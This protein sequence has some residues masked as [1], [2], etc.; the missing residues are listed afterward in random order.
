MR[1]EG[2]EGPGCFH[3]IVRRAAAAKRELTEDEWDIEVVMEILQ[4]EIEH[5][6]RAW[7]RSGR[8]KLPHCH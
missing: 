4:R 1:C 7:Q 5:S 2:P 8:L 3:K 6:A